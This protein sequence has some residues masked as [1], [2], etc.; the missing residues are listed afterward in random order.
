MEQRVFGSSQFS[1]LI[2]NNSLCILEKIL[3]FIVE[4]QCL[5]TNDVMNT[6]KLGFY[7]NEHS[8]Q[9]EVTVEVFDEEDI[10]KY[11]DNIDKVP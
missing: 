4:D 2:F 6:L 3:D 11:R 9:L 7:A 1:D 10:M 5:S 8:R